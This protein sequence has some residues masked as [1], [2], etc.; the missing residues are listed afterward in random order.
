MAATDLERK[1][2]EIGDGLLRVEGELKALDARF[3]AH[4]ADDRQRHE[5]LKTSLGEMREDFRAI[6]KDSAKLL[7]AMLAALVLFGC[8]VGGLGGLKVWLDARG[9]TVHVEPATAVAP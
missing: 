4:D 7:R 5:D 9:S 6:Q 1:V 8:L 3:S 2:D